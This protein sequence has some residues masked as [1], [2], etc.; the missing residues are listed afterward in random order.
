MI[1]FNIW[2]G[3]LS[4]RSRVDVLE[5]VVLS[6][7]IFA[8]VESV[9]RAPISELCHQDI[10][11]TQWKVMYSLHVCSNVFNFPNVLLHSMQSN[12]FSFMHL[13]P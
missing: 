2:V 8:L 5:H 10:F 11:S 12:R 6:N 1:L 4:D 3:E 13:E 7:T 9:P